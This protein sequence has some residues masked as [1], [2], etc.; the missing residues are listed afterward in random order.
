MKVVCFGYVITVTKAK[1]EELCSVPIP[2]KV[3]LIAREAG[4]MEEERRDRC[5]LFERLQ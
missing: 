2:L 3:V 5:S 4:T 1:S